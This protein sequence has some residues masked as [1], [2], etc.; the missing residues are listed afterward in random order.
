MVK[1]F[2]AEQKKTS[3]H[4]HWINFIS[5]PALE[6]RKRP[7]VPLPPVS[8]AQL[9]LFISS[10]IFS[11]CHHP[12]SRGHHSTSGCTCWETLPRYP[13]THW[14]LKNTF[15]SLAC[16][17]NAC[18]IINFK[19]CHNPDKGPSSFFLFFSFFFH[20]LT[21]SPAEV[22]E[23]FFG[24]V[25]W[26]GGLIRSCVR[27]CDPQRPHRI[28]VFTASTPPSLFCFYYYLFCFVLFFCD[29]PAQCFSVAE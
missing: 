2:N 1:I 4:H 20:P 14:N 22:S 9:H 6:E 28:S 16:T 17:C 3:H 11:S 25:C 21:I 8:L 10:F 27:P 12:V 24:D 23:Q 18:F 7:S 19:L 26:A 13:Q 15:C 5:M 29:D